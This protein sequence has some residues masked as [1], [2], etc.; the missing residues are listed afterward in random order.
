MKMK[1]LWLSS[2]LKSLSPHVANGD[3]IGQRCSNVQS[4]FYTTRLYKRER[5][6]WS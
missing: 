6:N 3:K 5:E 2:H 1:K 4:A